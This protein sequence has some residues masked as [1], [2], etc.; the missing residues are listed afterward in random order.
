MQ[1]N[2]QK[3]EKSIVHLEATIPAVQFDQAIEHAFVRERSRFSV[4]GFRKGHAPR[5]IVERVYGF[6]VFYDGAIDDL[7]P[8]VLEKACEEYNLDIIGRPQLNVEH[9]KEGEDLKLGFTFAVYPEVKL[10]EYKKLS[11]ERVPADV[12][13]A[14]VQ[15]EL[16]RARE[17]RARY[18]EV[19]RPIQQGD[20]IVFDY[21]GKIGD[22]YFEGGTA[23]KAQLDIGSNRFI[24]GFEE[25]MVGVP[26]N[27][28]REIGVKFPDDYQAEELKGKQA[29]FE[30]FVHEIR[31]KE[32]PEID[33]DLAMDATDFDTLA[34]WKADIEAKLTLEA[35]RSARTAMNNAL[36]EQAAQNATFEIPD[37]MVDSQVESIIR[38][39]AN[40]LSYQGIRLEDYMA[41]AGITIEQMRA[42][43][44][45]DAQRRVRNQIVL[46]AITKAEGIVVTPEETAA[47][48]AELS[49]RY[50]KSP[51]EFEKDLSDKDREYI[52]EDIVIEKTLKFLMDNAI[53]TQPEAKA[54]PAPDKPKKKRTK[55][56]ESSGTPEQSE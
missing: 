42:D 56:P 53:V 20:R 47:R 44:R 23:E 4:Q 15:A 22:E 1:T 48:V 5:K 2:L 50:E 41:Y 35:E 18:V 17:A 52:E 30:V 32:L 11:V 26:K 51:E 37:A 21:R 55:K 13:N 19:D 43:V 6:D 16:E 29:T 31:V 45:G 39:Y 27:E 46:D 49:G 24:P 12:D 7:A 8:G 38:D 9:A 3:R 34:Q 40:R 10:G 14:K 25:A 33:D 28:Q 54:E 36:L